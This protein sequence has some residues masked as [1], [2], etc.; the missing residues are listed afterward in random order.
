MS[1]SNKHYHG[2]LLSSCALRSVCLPLKKWS[3]CHHFSC[4]GRCSC[5]S[6]QVPLVRGRSLLLSDRS[7]RWDWKGLIT[8]SALVFLILVF[9]PPVLL[10]CGYI[11]LRSVFRRDKPSPIFSFSGGISLYLLVFI[12]SVFNSYIDL[13]LCSSTSQYSEN[14]LRWRPWLMFCNRSEERQNNIDTIGGLT[15]HSSYNQIEVVVTPR[16][17][18]RHLHY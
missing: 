7:P 9:D 18:N 10:S 11:L 17:S 3:G 8:I 2:T 14:V 5:Y 6:H 1:G 13:H 4:T 12:K 15:H 16:H